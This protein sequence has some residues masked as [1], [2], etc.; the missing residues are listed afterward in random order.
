M[1]L[2][3]WLRERLLG[4]SNDDSN[5]PSIAGAWQ[6][7]DIEAPH[8]FGRYIMDLRAE[9]ALEWSALVPTTGDGEFEVS[10]SGTWRIDGDN[11][12]YTSGGS[13]GTLRWSHDDGTLVLDGLP[14]T[15]IGPGVR[16]VLERR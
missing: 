1:S 11:L 12:H 14:A 3:R 7:T 2:L 15:K 4:L 8:P 6:V 16:C 5:V 9:G 13:G 10:G